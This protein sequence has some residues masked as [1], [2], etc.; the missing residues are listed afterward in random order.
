MYVPLSGLQE[1]MRLVESLADLDDP[2]DFAGLALP[3]LARLLG[4]D[5]LSFAVIGAEPGQV[6]VSCRPAYAAPPATIEAFT[7]FADEHPLVSHYRDTGDDRPARISDFLSQRQF[8]QLGLYAEVFRHIPIEYQIA[9]T[10]PGPGTD[11][12]GI[13]FNRVARDF[14]EDDRDLLSVIRVPLLTALSRAR[15][16]QRAQASLAT[17][18]CGGLADLTDR[19]VRVLRLAALGRTNTAIAHALDVS[20]RT[21][22]KHLE[23]I[24]RKLDVTSRAS[25]VFA[26][27]AVQE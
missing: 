2:A 7:R 1:A 6:S 22:A 24:Y 17:A 10:L 4:C 16:R 27:L 21:V 19:E 26:A 5:S 14:T 15:Q 13:A 3:R 25:A 12:I 11:V 23:H 8:H 18:N 20:P 9:F